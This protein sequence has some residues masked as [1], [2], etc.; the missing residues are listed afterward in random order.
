MVLRPLLDLLYLGRSVRQLLDYFNFFVV[1]L[2][3]KRIYLQKRQRQRLFTYFP[4]N[5]LLVS[6]L[7]LRE[8][9]CFGKDKL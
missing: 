1:S 3:R 6:V 4:D 5:C 8:Y 7:I 2:P 9:L